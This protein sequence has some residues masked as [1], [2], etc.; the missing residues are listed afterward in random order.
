MMRR[1]Y[2]K[3]L[4][5]TTK[6]T[7]TEPSG[8][9]LASQLT[10]NIQQIKQLL[11]GPND[12]MIRE[13]QLDNNKK[14][15]CAVVYMDGLIDKQ[16]V[17]ESIIKNLQSFASNQKD[18]KDSTESFDSIYQSFLSIHTVE[19]ET[20]IEN[21]V[22]G[23]LSGKTALLIDGQ[24]TAIIL[25]TKGGEARSIEAPTSEMV[26]RGPRAAFV[27]SLGSNLALLRKSLQTPSLRFQT[28]QIGLRSKK[29]L[30]V[31]YVN[32]VVN[33]AILE[34]VNRRIKSID[35]DDAPESGYVEQWI[36][37]SFLSP[38]PQINNTER[39]DRASAALLQGKVVILLDGSPFVLIAPFT[40]GDFLKSPED[41]YERWLIGSFLRFLR[42]IAVFFAMLL[43]ALY[44][45]LIS[46]HP[47]LLPTDMALS[48]AATREAVPFPPVV[49]AFL[50]V[51]TMELL[52]EAGLRL[53]SPIGQT[54]GIVGGLVI[55]DAAVSAGVVS[56][57]MVIV[58]GLTAISAFATPS[59]SIGVS[60][61]LLRLGFM[62][63]AAIL[64]LYGI[65][66][67]YIMV[68][69]H[70]VNL[71]SFGIPYT[72]P[73]APTRLRDWKDLVLR[74]P[75]TFLMRRPK[76]METEAIDSVKKR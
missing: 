10:N 67:V 17:Q 6:K 59:F 70:M 21:V 39:S 11:D 45:S 25:S 72:T 8:S 12:L 28:H 60:F 5:L 68:M 36:E 14:L 50:M 9:K 40:M 4:S 63:A 75:M 20:T 42:Y 15:K 66:L 48:I 7:K 69:I 52:Q 27:E 37:D 24:A 18:P 51:L 32:G 34:E 53:P 19:K 2:I 55:G 46:V 23:I 35:I 44:I 3:K 61:R 31:A 30:V 41:Y 62:I 58:I 16:L 73:F 29:G 43:P 33:P 65:I 26:V 22:N 71:K 56:P 49:E 38:F 54:I 13:L 76:F 74:A 47:G 1:R 64:G 57:I